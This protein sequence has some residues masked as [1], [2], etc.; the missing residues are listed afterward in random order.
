MEPSYKVQN[1][2]QWSHHMRWETSSFLLQ[3]FYMENQ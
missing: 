3:Y 2:V 1:V